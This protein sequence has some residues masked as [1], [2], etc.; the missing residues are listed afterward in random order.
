MKNPFTPN[1]FINNVQR[2]GPPIAPIPKINCNP[3][4]AATNFSLGTKSLVCAKFNEKSG[5]AKLEYNP[6]AKKNKILLFANSIAKYIFASED[7]ETIIA[8]RAKAALPNVDITIIDLRS[9]L[10]DK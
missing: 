4:P 3:P 9:Y 2:I 6:T 5:K 7:P 8:K 10:S 1:N